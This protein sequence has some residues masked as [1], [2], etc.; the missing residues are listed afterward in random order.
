MISQKLFRNADVAIGNLL[1]I[2]CDKFFV[3]SRFNQVLAVERTIHRDFA[4]IAA[5][6]G[7][8]FAI[9]AGTVAAR[10]ARVADLAFHDGQAR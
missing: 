1:G 10:L 6:N 8:N 2:H 3:Q 5:A 9:D 4:L 7:A